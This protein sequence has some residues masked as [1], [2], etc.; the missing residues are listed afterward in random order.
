MGHVI[1]SIYIYYRLQEC[2]RRPPHML[3]S[4]FWM[5]LFRPSKCGN[6][7][8]INIM[9]HWQELLLGALAPPSFL[10]YIYTCLLPPRFF[11]CARTRASGAST[12]TTCATVGG[13]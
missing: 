1:S 3:L 8:L 2:R 5:H 13:A 7:W 9:L 6:K 10:N 11:A 12:H 4:C